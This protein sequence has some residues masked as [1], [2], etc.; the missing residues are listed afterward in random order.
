MIEPCL[1]RLEFCT[2]MIIASAISSDRRETS[3]TQL[4]DVFL[5]PPLATSS[6]RRF[7]H[8]A[9]VAGVTR[10]ASAVCEVDHARTARSSRIDMRSVGRYCGRLWRDPPKA[11]VLDAKLLLRPGYELP[12]FI[13]PSPEPKSGVAAVG[14]PASGMGGSVLG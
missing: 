9:T 2:A 12:E 3:D 13:V 4:D 14:R 1:P 10:N 5:A 11:S 6:S 7:I 8:D